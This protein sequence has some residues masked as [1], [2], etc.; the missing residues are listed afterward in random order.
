M[1]NARRKAYGNE[2]ALGES[3]AGRRRVRGLAIA[4]LAGLWLLPLS[5]WLVSRSGDGGREVLLI[6]LT[7]SVAFSVAGG[8]LWQ[9]LDRLLRRAERR[10]ALLDTL[11]VTDPMTGV[12]NHRG[13]MDMLERDFARGRRYAHPLSLMRLDIDFFRRINDGYGHAVGD[14]VIIELATTSRETLR[15]NIDLLG[16]LSGAGFAILLP[17]TTRADASRFAERLRE[18]IARIEIETLRGD[19][20]RFTVSIGVAELAETDDSPREFLARAEHALQLAKDNGRNRVEIS[21]SA[22]ES[23]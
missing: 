4:L 13:F 12:C 22:A 10:D 2:Q 11:A 20:V 8:L 18:R 19:R 15:L 5:L 23:S 1:L 16:R 6:G 17:D 21:L 7:F 9:W 14:E 3:P